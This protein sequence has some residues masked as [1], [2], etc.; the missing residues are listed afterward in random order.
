M[1]IP[2]HGVVICMAYS[3]HRY[4]DMHAN[5]Y[6]TSPLLDGVGICMA[7]HMMAMQL[8]VLHGDVYTIRT[9]T[10]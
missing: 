4:H 2:A 1:D 10:P 3:W 5:G 6:T 7:Y 8:H 9:N